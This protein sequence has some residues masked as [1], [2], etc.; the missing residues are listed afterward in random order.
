MKTE[1]EYKEIAEAWDR[2][3]NKINEEEKE[4]EEEIE[5]TCCNIEIT[6]VIKDNNVCPD[7]GE[8]L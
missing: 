1:N 4:T 8:H 7:C 3:L 6:Q 5:Y 2:I